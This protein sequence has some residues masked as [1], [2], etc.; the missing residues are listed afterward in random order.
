LL[1]GA[2]SFPL[3]LEDGPR[4]PKVGQRDPTGPPGKPKG[5]Q[6]TASGKPMAPQTNK[7]LSTFTIKSFF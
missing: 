6:R 2:S 4:K 1:F 5:L 7:K 3:N